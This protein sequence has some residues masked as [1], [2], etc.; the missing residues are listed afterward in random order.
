MVLKSIFGKNKNDETKAS[1]EN[2]AAKAALAASSAP[3][4]DSQPAE[5]P[6]AEYL[7]KAIVDN[8][9]DDTN[10]TRKKLYQEL[11][12]SDLLLALADED[13]AQ[14]NA[15]QPQGTQSIAILTNPSG[16][17]FAVAFSSMAAARRWRADGGRYM[18]L[19][20][21]DLYK[22]LEPSPAEV[23]VLNP[24]SAPFVVLP[25]PDYKQ[26]ALGLIPQSAHSPVQVAQGQPGAEGDSAPA[27]GQMQI[28]FPPDVFDE[29]QRSLA[30]STMQNNA[31]IEA[32]A[33]GAIQ[34]PAPEPGKEAPWL[35]TVFIRVNGVEDAG[36]SMQKFC[37]EV[38]DAIRSTTSTLD[39]I[40]FEVAVMPDPDFWQHLQKNQLI[41]FDKNP[42][43][44]ADVTT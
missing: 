4:A 41:L 37:I 36:E 42:S 35:R 30:L 32:A 40:P 24:G 31:Q 38:R 44:S 5:P 12:F 2:N 17:Q 43:S 15:Q 7:E 6:A 27:E 18:S 33:L 16:V 29:N 8:A 25:K 28:A 13:P 20:G 9:R 3:G 11:L 22:L 39:D 34:P 14:Q 10:E 21:Q 19:R 1:P 23:I 26:L